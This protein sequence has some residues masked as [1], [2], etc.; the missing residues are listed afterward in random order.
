MTIFR[1]VLKIMVCRRKI[2]ES[3]LLWILG[4][5][6]EFA[7]GSKDIICLV[8]SSSYPNHFRDISESDGHKAA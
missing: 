1:T 8:L 2:L 7:S 6:E 4:V 3:R 5:K